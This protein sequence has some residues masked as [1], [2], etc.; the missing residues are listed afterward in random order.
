MSDIER[1]R[2]RKEAADSVTSRPP[3]D[4]DQSVDTALRRYLGIAMFD[5]LR[6]RRDARRTPEPPAAGTAGKGTTKGTDTTKGA[7]TTRKPGPRS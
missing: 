6:R 5:A 2:I 3:R 4:S 1:S 7:A